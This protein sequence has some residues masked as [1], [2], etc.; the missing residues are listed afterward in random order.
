MRGGAVAPLTEAHVDG[1][2]GAAPPLLPLGNP[3]QSRKDVGDKS[4]S[5]GRPAKPPRTVSF[6]AGSV[7][8]SGA[9]TSIVQ[10]RKKSTVDEIEQMQA[11]TQAGPPSNLPSM[12]EREE[13]HDLP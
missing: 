12:F 8:K 2:A 10:S 4:S 9:N 13:L 3:P 11:V 6:R 7:A 5:N 1:A